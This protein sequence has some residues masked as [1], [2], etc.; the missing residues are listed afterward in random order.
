M[1]FDTDRSGSISLSEL[2]RALSG[3]YS[4]KELAQAFELTDDN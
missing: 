2:H 1:H 3:Q 4:Y